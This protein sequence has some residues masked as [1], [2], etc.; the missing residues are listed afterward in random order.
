[1]LRGERCCHDQ[2]SALISS[3]SRKCFLSQLNNFMERIVPRT[4]HFDM[5]FWT[6]LQAIQPRTE[7]AV[8][9]V[10][11]VKSLDPTPSSPIP[12]TARS[13]E[14]LTLL[15]DAEYIAA[16]REAKR[17]ESLNYRLRSRQSFQHL[18]MH[19]RPSAPLRDMPGDTLA[20]TEAQDSSKPQRDGSRGGGCL[21]A[22]I[23]EVTGFE[24]PDSAAEELVNVVA[25]SVFEDIQ[26]FSL[27]TTASLG[28]RSSR[29]FFCQ[30]RHH[31]N[32]IE[33]VTAPA[34]ADDSCV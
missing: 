32:G 29:I 7:A 22:F 28:F 21:G 17:P 12:G 25:E 30:K 5:K 33:M 23:F 26:S 1:M 13:P 19:N 9:N 8:D 4:R 24:R 10:F 34:C 2:R 18:T 16:Y 11:W 27:K 3:Q 20:G 31:D 14:L 6:L 15:S